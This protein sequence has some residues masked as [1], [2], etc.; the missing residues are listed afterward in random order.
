MFEAKEFTSVWFFCCLIFWGQWDLCFDVL[1]SRISNLFWA[2]L[3][4]IV[5]HS[6]FSVQHFPAF[7]VLS[8]IYLTMKKSIYGVTCVQLT[9]KVWCLNHKTIILMD[10]LVLWRFIAISIGK[11]GICIANGQFYLRKRCWVIKQI[12]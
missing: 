7:T 10:F 1:F 9:W 8:A 5:H 2:K 6:V 12:A 4:F 3:M 11:W